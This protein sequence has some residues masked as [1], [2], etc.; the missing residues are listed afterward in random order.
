MKK[1]ETKMKVKDLARVDGFTCLNPDIG[2]EAQIKSAYV[3]DLLSW[4]MANA[5]DG[6]AWITIQTH[7]N[8]VAVATLLE[9]ACI[10]IPEGAEIESSALDRA[11]L[12]DIPVFQTPLTAYEVCRLLAKAG[13]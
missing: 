2:L 7:V 10:I 6:C 4:V 1:K 5:E 3:G 13:I 11:I 12:E 9:M 8:I